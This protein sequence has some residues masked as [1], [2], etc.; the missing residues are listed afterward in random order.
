M[1]DINQYRYIPG[2]LPTGTPEEHAWVII[3]YEK[4]LIM[5]RRDTQ[6]IIPEVKDT[7]TI[8]EEASSLEYIGSYDGNSCYC[9][10]IADSPMLPEDLVLVELA[11][12][13]K[14][15]GDAGLFLLAGAANHILHWN[16][17]N[18]YC[19]FCGTRMQNKRDERAKVCPSCSNTVYPRIS[20]AVITAVFREDK[21]LL[22]HNCN[23]RPG[24][25]SLIAGFV[26]PGETLEQC[27]AREIREEVGIRV[28]NI[29]YYDSQPWSFPDS[30]ML[31]FTA[32][33]DGGEIVTDNVEIT[34]A[35][36]YQADSLPE[37]PSIDSIAGRLIR[38]YRD[39][40]YSVTN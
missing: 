11:D 27:V 38:W 19:G 5:K 21:I 3:L 25:Y 6:L 23:F 9:I 16:S 18:R 4:K 39:G 30:L 36:W 37:I 34:E 12:I 24:M 2:F 17:R 32:D 28:R 14:K 22:A 8:W 26:E 29:R 31:A 20:P 35:N 10:R 33:Y 1:S 13:T 7:I 40:C 15:S